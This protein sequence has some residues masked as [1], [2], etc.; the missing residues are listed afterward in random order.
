MSNSHLKMAVESTAGLLN[1]G[2][3]QKMGKVQ[4]YIRDG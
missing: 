3:S 1:I 4:R 2:L